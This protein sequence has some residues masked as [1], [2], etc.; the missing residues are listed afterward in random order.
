MGIAGQVGDARISAAYE[1]TILS[2]KRHGKY[3]GM[4]GV[5]QE[6]ILRRAIGMGMRFIL[7]G[8]DLPLLLNAGTG[9]AKML[10]SCG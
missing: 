6:D 5:S 4:G 2:A 9:L 1:K 3:P 8:N 10:R 7:G